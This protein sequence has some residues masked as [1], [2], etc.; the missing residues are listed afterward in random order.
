MNGCSMDSVGLFHAV[1]LNS[2]K[3]T[4]HVQEL[5]GMESSVGTAFYYRIKTVQE[6]N[7]VTVLL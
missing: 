5:L 3:N 1:S 7:Q 2:T 4:A 6:N